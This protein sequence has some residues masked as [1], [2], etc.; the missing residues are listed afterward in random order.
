MRCN[1]QRGL[2]PT[3]VGYVW[4]TVLLFLRCSRKLTDSHAYEG[5]CFAHNTLETLHTSSPSRIFQSNCGGH[6]RMLCA[7]GYVG[8]G[9]EHVLSQRL[10]FAYTF[11]RFSSSKAAAWRRARRHAPPWVASTLRVCRCFVSRVLL[12]EK[13][14]PSLLCEGS[15]V[16]C[17]LS[18][19]TTE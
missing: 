18:Y 2:K 5:L 8:Y 16:A 19:C 9:G 12:T 1:R 11:R 17:C 4:D 6:G 14:R 15:L 13:E 10:V 7:A 3:L